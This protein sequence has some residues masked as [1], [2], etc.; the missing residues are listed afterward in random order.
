MEHLTECIDGHLSE[1]ALSNLYDDFANNISDH[2]HAGNFS[3]GFIGRMWECFD[4]K[5]DADF[6]GE[7]TENFVSEVANEFA[8]ELTGEYEEKPVEDMDQVI[9]EFLSQQGD[10]IAKWAEEFIQTVPNRLFD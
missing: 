9:S 3:D 4:G 2:L 1:H 8:E 6:I 5:L 10:K 7:L